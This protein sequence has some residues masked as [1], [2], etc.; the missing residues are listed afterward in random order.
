VHSI[1]EIL[2]DSGY[3][4]LEKLHIKTRTPKKRANKVPLT[5]EDKKAN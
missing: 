3:Q 1:T 4:G 2:A 5:P